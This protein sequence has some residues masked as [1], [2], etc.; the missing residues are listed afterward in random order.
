MLETISN[1]SNGL[2][3]LEILIE[4]FEKGQ[5]IRHVVKIHNY[6]QSG[7]DFLGDIDREGKHISQA[8]ENIYDRLQN[9]FD[10]WPSNREQ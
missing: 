1:I 10:H 5:G 9:I 4:N 8:L 6:I 2:K 7:C 3:V